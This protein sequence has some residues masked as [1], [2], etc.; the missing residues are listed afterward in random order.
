M[1]R[2]LGT[3][4]GTFWRISTFSFES[5]AGAERAAERAGQADEPG[6]WRS[7]SPTE[8]APRG[9]ISGAGFC[10]LELLRVEQFWVNCAG[11][12][13]VCCKCRSFMRLPLPKIMGICAL[14][15]RMVNAVCGWGCGAILELA[16]S[17]IPSP[18]SEISH[19]R[20]GHPPSSLRDFG[21]NESVSP[22]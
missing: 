22:R 2:S 7:G 4:A 9:A 13:E 3:M 5:R 18:K 21:W 17:R 15:Q 1:A 14:L 8:I 12:G 10:G 16:D 6:C 19:G 11:V 20:M